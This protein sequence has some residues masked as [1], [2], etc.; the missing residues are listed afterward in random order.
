MVALNIVITR[1]RDFGW[2]S[3]ISLSLMAVTVVGGG[4]FLKI[5]KGKSNGFIDISLFKNNYFTGATVS[6]FLLNAVAGALI[7]ANT[8]VQVARGYT[9]FQ[10]GLL[11]L[12]NL[13][14]RI[15]NDSCW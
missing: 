7:V 13:I 2:T 5:V 4:L 1:G 11:S 12:G 9:S 6:N 14:C 10:S 8:Y 3:P 15:S